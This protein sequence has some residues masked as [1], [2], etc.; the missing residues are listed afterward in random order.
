MYFGLSAGG[1]SDWLDGGAGA[2]HLDGGADGDWLYGRAGDDELRGG[3]GDD[4]L[5]G[6]WGSDRLVGGTGN[7]YYVFE[8]LFGNDTIVE[9]P[10]A[11][12]DSMNFGAVTLP[13][14]V[15]LG[16]VNVTGPG[17]SVTYAGNSIEEVVGGTADDTFVM[18]APTVVFNGWLDGGGGTNTLRYDDATPAITAAVAA[19]QKPN[20]WGAFSFA[21]V[22][23]VPPASMITLLVPAGT[24]T[25][26]AIT[27]TGISQIV[28]QGAGTLV[29][30]RTNSHSGGTLVEAGEVIVKSVSALGIG[31]LE[32][33][34]GAKATFDVGQNAIKLGFIKFD[35]LV[36]L[37]EASMTVASGLTS[38]SL[39]AALA[40][41]RG[42]GSWNGSHGIASSAAAAQTAAGVPRAIGW[43][44][45]GDG[46]FTIGYTAPGDA[47]LD[48]RVDILDAANFIAS[49]KFDTGQAATWAEGNFNYDL[50]VDILDVADF[51]NGSTVASLPLAATN[52]ATPTTDTTTLSM[53]DLVF[54]ALA[55]NE[56]SRTTTR[57][58]AFAVL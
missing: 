50:V 52:A 20:V 7:D 3:G 38:A 45:N 51:F 40:A 23:A 1:G 44:D 14:E 18:T 58:K 47:N 2:D 39:V 24:T 37:G 28:K 41:G 33:A 54:A 31:G 16:S 57:K 15:R 55:Q 34:A 56:Q 9:D 5:A 8:D 30:D 11:G 48:K 22:V 25:T 4:T 21:S 26:D 46:S 32:V 12:T 43:T 35:G 10:S 42:D 6:G 36:N 19:G 27:R 49:G 17:E 53:G 29:L 13:L